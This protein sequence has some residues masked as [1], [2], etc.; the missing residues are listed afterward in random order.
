[1]I[2]TASHAAPGTIASTPLFTA[3]SG[4]GGVPSNIFFQIDDS[5]SMDWE[6]IT[7]KYWHSSLYDPEN[8][9]VLANAN[10]VIRQEQT[11]ANFNMYR[12]TSYWSGSTG[13][14]SGY[15]S[16]IKYIY[17]DPDIVA[18][19]TDCREGLQPSPVLDCIG[20]YTLGSNTT[21][22]TAATVAASLLSDWRIISAG[23]NLLYYNPDVDYKPWKNG[24]GTAMPDAD[25]TAAKN[26]PLSTKTPRDLTGFQ[27]EVW[28]D[29]H[30]YSGTQPARI[31]G[32]G[33]GIIK[34][35]GTVITT[36]TTNGVNRTVGANGRVDLWDEHT[37]YTVNANDITQEEIKYNPA[38][39]GSGSYS[40]NRT[41][42]STANLTTGFK[43][44]TLAQEKTNIANWYQYYR[45]RM[46]TAKASV[47]TIIDSNP[48]YRYGFNTIWN[49]DFVELPSKYDPANSTTLRTN[50]VSHNKELLTKLFKLSPYGETPLPDALSRVGQYFMHQA[51]PAIGSTSGAGV[52]Y[53]DPI[54]YECQQNF[55][56]M[57]TDGYWNEDLNAS[58]QS[59]IGN[60][61]ADG[62]G[63]SHSTVAD[64]ARYYYQTD[65]NTTLSDHV[66]TNSFDANPKQH[67]V[68]FAVAFGLI[69]NL[70]DTDGNGWPDIDSV[71]HLTGPFNESGNWGDPS[72]GLDI[73][74]KNDDL[75]HA[76]YNS[77]GIFVSASSPEK[78]AAGFATIFENIAQRDYKGSS[79]S[80]SFN[81]SKISGGN[82]AYVSQFGLVSNTWSG[83]LIAY[84][85]NPVNGIISDTS[86][87]RAA[88]ELDK[89]NATDKTN[90]ASKRHIFTYNPSIKKGVPFQWQK[91]SINP[92]GV[93]PLPSLPQRDL[94]TNTSGAV[95]SGLTTVEADSVNKPAIDRLKYL[96]GDQSNEGAAGNHFRVRPYTDNNNIYHN[97]LLGDIIHSDP[98][99]VSSPQGSWPTRAPFP[100]VSGSRYRD[101]KIAHSSRSPM[102]YVG[103]NDGMLHAF[104]AVDGSE[105]MGYIPYILFSDSAATSGLHYLTDPAYIGQNHRYYVDA[106]PIIE[107]V[108]IDTQTVGI[109]SGEQWHTIL[110][111]GL[112]A[113][114]RGIY[115][116]DVTD[117]NLF[118]TETDVNAEKI[119]LWEFNSTN[120]PDM[121]YS[122]AMPSIV[123]MNN[124]RWAAVFGNGYNSSAS[125][126]AALFIVFLDGGVDGVWT[127]G[128]GGTSQ[129]YIKIMTK[130]STTNSKTGDVITNNDCL[131]SAS[132]CNGL[133]TPQT[134]DLNADNVIDRIY[135]GDLKGNLWAFDVSGTSTSSWGVAYGSQNAPE[136]LFTASHH[137]TP[138]TGTDPKIPVQQLLCGLVDAKT[139][140]RQPITSRPTVIRNKKGK[141]PT[142]PNLLVLFGT[143]QYLNLADTS[144]KDIQ[145]FYAVWDKGEGSLTPATATTTTAR[146]IEQT[147]L[148]GP[149]ILPDGATDKVRVLTNY[150]VVYDT[151]STSNYG[152]FVNL[153][154]AEGERQIVNTDVLDEKYLFFN[155]WIPGKT[156]TIPTDSCTIEGSTSGSGYLMSVDLFT[157][158]RADKPLFDLNKSGSLGEADKVQDDSKNI[159]PPSGHSYNTGLPGSSNFIKGLQY[160][161]GTDAGT[162][163]TGINV[164]NAPGEQMRRRSWQ[165]LRLE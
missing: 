94:A 68:T 105:A 137:M 157:G 10:N 145:S 163:L 151:T 23:L 5:K 12:G 149:F 44:R 158:G 153:S 160:T 130:T 24:D 102:I 60:Y 2:A 125:G 40:L 162:N 13:T 87:W 159:Y 128:S 115:A 64:I 112:G 99:F 18:Y 117:P 150:P 98:I 67:L 92:T 43:E 14:T 90:A 61:D 91:L 119:V 103:A 1:M 156:S 104:N 123:M 34:K 83:D 110:V 70:L 114:G 7:N 124:N 116:L 25:F 73:P 41:V 121:G 122:F 3:T 139:A 111:G 30:G 47:A 51:L 77:K 141:G 58:S 39:M 154:E 131:N 75:W 126:E 35:V 15:F 140:C 78:I 56:V 53:A 134:V 161:P 66:P 20:S 28:H 97:N 86:R 19:A 57:Q 72:G 52:T 46:N 88:T 65:L 26:N 50:F 63:A 32:A 127:D 55:A 8:P 147:F 4:G 100:S 76:A 59:T 165:E 79:T 38:T 143:G 69:G 29:T 93:L 49:R 144:N 37:K 81:V 95:L 164:V 107:D 6:V 133:S 17:H 36:T 96:R 148:P 33:T 42:A 89:L 138:T 16:T 136:P 135:A 54:T 31:T 45:S 129:D 21:T 62:I 27:F 101:F 85:I 155:T 48:K 82:S 109:G 106:P 132:D 11:D 9:G 146:F 118:L 84:D 142:P 108:Y 74:Q 71:T 80:A 152:W 22:F 120:D 113:G